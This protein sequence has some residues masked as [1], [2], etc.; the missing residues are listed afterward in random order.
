MIDR[1]TSVRKIVLECRNVEIT[2]PT[3]AMR[4]LLPHAFLLSSH[5]ASSLAY[6]LSRQYSVETILSYSIL[7]YLANSPRDIH[8]LQRQRSNSPNAKHKSP[9]RQRNTVTS[10]AIDNIPH[11]G[12]LIQD[13]LHVNPTANHLGR[14]P[15]RPPRPG[16]VLRPR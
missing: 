14:F 3:D 16:F 15:E 8:S 6:I 2:L 11:D 5:P 10:N 7:S 12:P 9:P 1:G 13:P 4:N